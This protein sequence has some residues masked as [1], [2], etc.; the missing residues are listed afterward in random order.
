MPLLGDILG[1]NE[2]RDRLKRV[3]ERLDNMENFVK[4]EIEYLEKGEEKV[5]AVLD[6]AKT[7]K[8]VASALG[9]SR[10]WTSMVLN[11]LEKKGKVREKDMRGREILY[12][13]V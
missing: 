1:L 12:E 8:E 5:L 9:M 13:R 10:S 3:E 4:P 6:K 7:T 2:I 11:L